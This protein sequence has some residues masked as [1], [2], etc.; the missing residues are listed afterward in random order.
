MA[1]KP[2][3]P[4]QRDARIGDGIGR[5]TVQLLQWCAGAAVGGAG[6]ERV[7]GRHLF[8]LPQRS[9]LCLP[10]SRRTVIFTIF[11]FT[12]TFISVS[13]RRHRNQTIS[14]ADATSSAPPR[15]RYQR[16]REQPHHARGSRRQGAQQ[17]IAA[18][19]AASHGNPTA[20]FRLCLCLSL[21]L[22]TST[23]PPFVRTPNH[24]ELVPASAPEPST[25]SRRQTPAHQLTG[26]RFP[27]LSLA[28]ASH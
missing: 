25:A 22:P 10:P 21:L 18:S 27:A 19:A 24:W 28:E 13:R 8:A 15:R 5:D 4:L 26:G 7:R 23:S 16:Q 1:L 6:C 14:A 20:Q 12:S 3:A 9:C 11:I 17:R 2:A